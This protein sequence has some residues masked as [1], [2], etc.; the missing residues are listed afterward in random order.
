VITREFP[1]T[2]R[3]TAVRRSDAQRLVAALL[4]AGPQ[5]A[6]A[7]KSA[8]AVYGIEGVR[9]PRAE[10]VAPTTFRGR[11]EGVVIRRSD[12]RAA[13]RI[14]RYNEIR[15][16]G[17]EPTITALAAALDAEAFEVACED[18]RRRNLTS[19]RALYAYLDRHGRSGRPGVHALR[20]LLRELDPAHPARSTLEVK[21]R[22]LLVV[23]G[24]TG[25]TRELPLAWNGRTY[26]FDF[27]FEHEQTIVETNGRRWHDDPADYEHDNEKWSVPGRYGYR[28][29]LAT[30]AKVTR[31]PD[32]FVRD[33]RETLR[34]QMRSTSA[35]RER[36]V[37]ARSE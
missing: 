30:W 25:F 34:Y 15:V 4:W 22:R 33:L 16:T 20:A 13:L 5:S 21:M 28:L 36:S 35:P 6:G 3:L 18:A 37:A 19:T 12:D 32:E 11:T 26:H 9:P 29:V 31:H 8:G 7:S 10:I 2:Y 1:D 17:V 14:R 24:I 23:R 27:A